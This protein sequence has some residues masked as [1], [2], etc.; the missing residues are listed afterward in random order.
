M[1]SLSR[2]ANLNFAVWKGQGHYS[3]FDHLKNSP[4]V[5]FVPAVFIFCPELMLA[6]NGFLPCDETV[7]S[8]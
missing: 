8:C 3:N 2:M 7:G 1:N 6:S 5:A 4:L